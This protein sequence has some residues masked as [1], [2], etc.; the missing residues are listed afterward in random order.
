L[1]PHILKGMRRRWIYRTGSCRQ[2]PRRHL[3]AILMRRWRSHGSRE[4]LL[5]AI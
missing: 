3:R 2:K 4:L 5:T 1:I